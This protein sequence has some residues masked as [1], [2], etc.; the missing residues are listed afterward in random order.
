MR[1]LRL[2]AAAAFGLLVVGAVV[3]P[4]AVF[5]A[6][7][8]RGSGAR[9]ADSDLLAVALLVG[10]PYGV[11]V[12]QRLRSASGGAVDTWLSAVHGLVVLALTASALPAAGLHSSARL[13]ARVVDAEWPVL[14]A[15]GAMLGAAVLLAEVTRRL[16]LRW[17]RADPGSRS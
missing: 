3:A 4:A 16:S 17:L 8:A 12:Q 11:Y 2:T 1:L 9:G 15:W 7:T 10:L 14:L 6:S 5:A 13:H